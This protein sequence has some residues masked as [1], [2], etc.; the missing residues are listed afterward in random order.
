[1]RRSNVGKVTLILLVLC[2]MTACSSKTGKDGGNTPQ[3]ASQG[4]IVAVSQGYETSAVS[5]TLSKSEGSVDVEDKS[6]NALERRDGMF[7]YNGNRVMTNESSF[8]Y[9]SLDDSKA[10]KMNQFSAMEVRKEAKELTLYLE[11]GEM[12]FNVAKRLPDDEAMNIRTSTMVTGI[13]GTSGIVRVI[14]FYTTMIYVIDGEVMVTV[15][16]PVTGATKAAM[17]KA[18]QIATTA[19]FKDQRNTDKNVDITIQSFSEGDIPAYVVQEVAMSANLQGRIIRGG[20]LNSPTLIGNYENALARDKEENKVFLAQVKENE[21]AWNGQN[22]LLDEMFG[23]SAQVTSFSLTDPT[24]AQVQEALDNEQYDTVT[25]EG[26]FVFGDGSEGVTKLSSVR[27]V[28]R[29]WSMRN[30]D[31]DASEI[32]TIPAGKSLNLNGKTAFGSAGAIKNYGVLTNNGSLYLGGELENLDE[33]RFINNGTVI[34]PETTE[35]HV[36]VVATDPEVKATCT[37]DGLTRGSHCAV[38]NEILVP[39]RPIP[40]TGHKEEVVKAVDPSCEGTGLTEGVKCS[41]CGEILVAQEEVPPRGHSM[42]PVK[43]KEPTCTEVGHEAGNRCSICGRTDYRTIPALGHEITITEEAHAATCTE[44]GNTEGQFCERCQQWVTPV[45]TIEALGHNWIDYDGNDMAQGNYPATCTESGNQNQ[46]CTRCEEKQSVE[47]ESLG[48]NLV[49]A[50]SDEHVTY[51]APTCK[52]GFEELACTRCTYTERRILKAVRSH[53]IVEVP[54]SRQIL[55]CTQGGSYWVYCQECGGEEK[56]E[57]IDPQD[58]PSGTLD[59][60]KST[61]ATCADLGTLVYICN[62]CGQ[63]YTE[64]EER[65]DN[66]DFSPD[67]TTGE[68]PEYCRN[69]C[70]TPNPN[71]NGDPGNP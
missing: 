39:Q 58:H 5:V 16:D 10:A 2:L 61:H 40:A 42:V 26:T 29:G 60:S 44:P 6:G 68:L 25:V 28:K 32:L 18:G 50:Q 37:K 36:H 57:Y 3:G 30:V 34:T 56:E 69:G 22:D 19:V 13:R 49:R 55:D 43:E 47:L 51:Q 45:T 14:D 33:G 11:S 24:L 38:C 21:K 66:H 31:K 67:P 15:I 8:A 35:E 12:F 54:G 70:G 46:I 7:L 9:L 17:I 71:V 48:H 65:N 62:V 20:V 63:T 53:T 59:E 52:D 4:D 41:V 27:N 64:I 23:I 1:M